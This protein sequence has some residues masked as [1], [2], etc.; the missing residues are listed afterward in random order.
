[1]Y[2]MS[3]KELIRGTQEVEYILKDGPRTKTE[4]V[5]ALRPKFGTAHRTSPFL[6][7]LVRIGTLKRDV[8]SGTT[9]YE[10][11]GP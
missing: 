4:M 8:E 11:S 6:N 2:F 3:M 7:E 1:M 9:Y 10:W 5:L